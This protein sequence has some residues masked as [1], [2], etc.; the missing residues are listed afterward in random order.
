[1]W[2]ASHEK[3]DCRWVCRVDPGTIVER[4]TKLFVRETTIL[5]ALFLPPPKKMCQNHAWANRH[6]DPKKRNKLGCAVGCSEGNA[7]K[8]K[9]GD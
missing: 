5:L 8:G 3:P 2:P 4:I 9:T 7:E 1:M 6:A